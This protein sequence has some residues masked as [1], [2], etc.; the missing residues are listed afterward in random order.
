MKTLLVILAF[1][2][3]IGT[4]IFMKDARDT[5]NTHKHYDHY[6]NYNTK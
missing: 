1:L 6:S 5:S 4:M 3:I 2:V